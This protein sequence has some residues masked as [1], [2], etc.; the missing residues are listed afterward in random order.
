MLL[1]GIGDGLF[2]FIQP[3][4]LQEMGASPL[5]IGAIFSIFGFAVT[6]TPLPAGILADR[7]GRRPLIWSCFL[8][9]STGIWMMARATSLQGYTLGMVIYGASFFLNSP[10][11]SYATAARGKWTVTRAITFITNSYN[12]GWFIGPNLGGM[13]GDRYPLN[14]VYLAAALTITLAALVVLLIREQ[15]KSA[16]L[17]RDAGRQRWIFEP[18][19]VA[20]LLVIMLV[21][22]SLFLPQPLSPNFLVYQRG[23]T[24]G[25]AGHLASLAGLGSALLNLAIGHSSPRRGLLISQAAVGLFA[26]CIW[27]G[28]QMAWYVLGYLMLGGFKSMRAMAAAL[29]RNLCQEESMG[30]MY[31]MTETAGNLGASLSP[32]LAAA[33]FSRQAGWMY[34]ACVAGILV[35]MLVTTRFLPGKEG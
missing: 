18:G 3:V 21:N 6:I 23:I 17:S 19:I 35:S 1:W 9:G 14:K 30:W 22:F 28:D 10:L 24:I 34:A 8:L 4:Y 16:N 11:F 31:G 7:L 26:L 25:M 12:L 2:T 29:S 15:P 33:L 20:F 27:R 32:Y 5:Q 13:I